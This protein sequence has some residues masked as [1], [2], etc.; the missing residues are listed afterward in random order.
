[1]LR[2]IRHTAQTSR[3]FSNEVAR[4]ADTIFNISKQAAIHALNSL[5]AGHSERSYETVMQNY[6]YDRRI[7][8]KRQAR[9]FTTVDNDI[10]ETGILDIEVDHCVL[11]ELKVGSDT[12]NTDHKMQIHRYLRCA[13]L[14]NPHAS[15]I[16]AVFLFTKK[17][18][19]N[20][21]K[22]IDNNTKGSMHMQITAPST[23][24]RS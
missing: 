1:M 17:G 22:M 13:R 21:Y 12:I 14:K 10:I 5:G 6:L 2:H 15:L 18:T 20:I 16:A 7:P 9:Y 19:L 3:F 11:L 4:N 24:M 8:T 23:S